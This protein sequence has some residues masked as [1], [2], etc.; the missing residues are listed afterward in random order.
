VSIK[1]IAGAA[2]GRG[3][4]LTSFTA[5][6]LGVTGGPGTTVTLTL[7]HGFGGTGSHSTSVAV[8]VGANFPIK[9]DTSNGSAS[10]SSS[11]TATATDGA[12]DTASASPVATANVSHGLSMTTT[13]LDFGRIVSSAI[14]G[15]VNY[16]A[17]TNVLSVPSDSAALGTH[18]LGSVTITGEPNAA[19]SIG[20]GAGALK[21]G[22]V[23]LGTI[24]PTVSPGGSQFLVLNGNG[25]G[26]KTFKIGGKFTLPAGAAAGTYQGTMQVTAQY[27]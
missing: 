15:D 16:P 12:G 3:G 17:G 14:G 4:V 21:N 27:N 25:T 1:I 5:S 18:S 6:A 22:G 11:F 8:S 10:A 26:S 9:G 2:S 23:T 13:T 19:V 24:T 20:V 7:P